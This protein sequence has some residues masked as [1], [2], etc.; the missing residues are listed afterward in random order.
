MFEWYWLFL[1]FIVLHF[2]IVPLF[3]IYVHRAFGHSHATITPAFD[4][5]S[6]LSLWLT[7]VSGSYDIACMLQYWVAKHRKHHA[8]SDTGM[9]PHSPYFYSP[10]DVVFF[11][12]LSEG[13]AYYLDAKE[14]STLAPDIVNHRDDIVAH[15]IT[16]YSYLRWLVL[17]G[18]SAWLF[19]WYGVV[20]AIIMM[21]IWKI[22]PMVFNLVSHTVGYRTQE[23]CNRDDRSKNIFPIAIF[24]GGDDLAANHHDYPYLSNLSLRWFEFDLGYQWMRIYQYFGLLSI[25]DLKS[26]SK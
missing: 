1:Y 15:I 24:F 23:P 4:K 2:W 8:W 20:A 3:C 18:I 6:R 10:I 11:T 19:G 14:I 9:D 5:M 21:H 12:K 22:W 25:C 17:P 16:K 26:I 7:G 13:K